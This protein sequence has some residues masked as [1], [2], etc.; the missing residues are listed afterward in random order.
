MPLTGPQRSRIVDALL[1]AYSRDE[2]RKMVTARMNV[3]FV[4]HVSAEKAY[5]A[6]V[7]EFVEWA[8]RQGR[9]LE[10]LEFAASERK[11]NTGLQAL[12]TEALGWKAET[13][14]DEAQVAPPTTGDA[15]VQG[16]RR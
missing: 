1:A 2:L 6:Q 13:Q 4:R 10:L 7:F 5:E 9:A 12:W 15:P 3:D 14:P 8:D 11:Q 16:P